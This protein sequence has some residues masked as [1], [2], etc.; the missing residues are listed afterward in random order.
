MKVL[1]EVDKEQGDVSDRARLVGCPECGQK[2]IEVVDI[3]D[4]GLYRIKCR[5]C[6]RYLRLSASE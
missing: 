2:L 4:N 5:R 6:G 1:V 3:R